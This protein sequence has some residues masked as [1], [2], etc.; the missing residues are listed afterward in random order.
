MTDPAG[1]AGDKTMPTTRKWITRGRAKPV[2]P[3]CF[4]CFDG[5]D[6]FFANE[7]RFATRTEAERA[8]PSYRL[9]AWDVTRLGQVP[10]AATV[11]DGITADAAELLWLTWR[12]SGFD[13][14]PVAV[15][16]AAD[17]ASLAAFRRQHA[18]A[19][20]EIDDHLTLWAAWLDG[21]DAALAERTAMGEDFRAYTTQHCPSGSGATY[22]ERLQAGPCVVHEGAGAARY[23]DGP[24]AQRN[25]DF[26]V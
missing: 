20:T 13:P 22:G 24:Q 5:T 6:H 9:A 3:L 11:Y 16:L 21:L 14:R 23:G 15:A 25:E 19:T 26:D 2:A 10:R 7:P 8:W 12:T 18:K 4:V 17:R 1:R